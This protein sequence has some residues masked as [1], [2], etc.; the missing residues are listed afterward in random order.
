MYLFL[1]GMCMMQNAPAQPSWF[2][3]TIEWVNANYTSESL[4]A[5]HARL[6]PG[7][8]YSERELSR[9]MVRIQQ[10][11]WIVSA[12]FALRKGSER[13]RYRLVITLE[14]TSLFFLDASGLSRHRE[15]G[16]SDD[17]FLGLAGFRYFAGRYTLFYG[18]VSPLPQGTAKQEPNRV[19]GRLGLSH[20]NVFGKGIFFDAQWAY[21]GSDHVTRDL[22]KQ[23]QSISYEPVHSVTLEMGIPLARYQWIRSRAFIE[24][25][26]THV[27]N[28]GFASESVGQFDQ[29]QTKEERRRATFFWEQSTVN[30]SWIPKQG[31]TIR[32]GFSL[33]DGSNRE[34]FP[35][36]NDSRG[37]TWDTWS[38]FG[39]A[40]FHLPLTQQITG[41]VSLNAAYEKTE[42]FNTSQARIDLTR[43][44]GEIRTGMTLFQRHASWGDLALGIE[45]SALGTNTT[46]RSSNLPSFRFFTPLREY[47]AE[48][49]LSFRN[50]WFIGRFGVRFFDLDQETRVIR[51]DLKP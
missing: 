48:V 34:L 9:A 27:R 45:A 39:D 20:F 42:E 17:L 14:E 10:L 50:S 6:Q 47:R 21:R 7:K 41:F 3:E 2:L 51:N 16:D 31:R 30:D 29:L 23:N 12:R 26:E 25:E 33:A 18:S 38:L 4:L 46:T 15:G 22:G 36:A 13:G 8:E 37:K 19:G 44:V 1:M 24:R 28:D 11:P 5:V 49:F 43:K 40:E 35:V 32:G